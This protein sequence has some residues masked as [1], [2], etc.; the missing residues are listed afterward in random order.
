VGARRSSRL[1]TLAIDEANGHLM[2]ASTGRSTYRE[3]E[4]ALRHTWGE[5]GQLFASYTR[6]SARG[7]VND[8]STLF[9]SGDTEVLRPGGVARLGSDAPNRLLA[10]ATVPLLAGFGVSPALEWR[11]GFPYSVVDGRQE[12]VSAPNTA[13]FPA[14]FSLDLVV[15]KA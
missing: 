5:G 9:A 6:S 2:V 1:A 11:S 15:D 8:F 3:A 7:E 13:S 4:V 14:F 10:W 12:Y